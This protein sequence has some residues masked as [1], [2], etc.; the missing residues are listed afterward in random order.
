MPANVEIKARVADLERLRVQLERA[1]GSAGELLIQE[2]VFFRVE[3][4]RLKLRIFD[5]QHGELI[6]Y[7]RPDQPGPKL[8]KYTIAPTSNPSALRRILE[9][10]LGVINVVRKHRLLFHL[11]ATRVHLDR[12]EGL[13]DF[14]ELEVVLEPGQ[15]AAEGARRAEQIMA[16]LHIKQRD[17]VSQAYIDLIAEGE[18][19]SRVSLKRS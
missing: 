11:G 12:V 9:D 4:G 19:G 14:I 17:L 1:T 18:N 7:Q 13:G 8:S 3:K 10:A 16:D 5:E 2:D 6:A 15:S